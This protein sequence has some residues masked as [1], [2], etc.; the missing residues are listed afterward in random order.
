MTKTLFSLRVGENRQ[1]I[2]GRSD[3]EVNKRFCGCLSELVFGLGMVEI[4]TGPVGVADHIPDHCT[5]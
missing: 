2:I 1:I 5:W 3:Q 4:Q